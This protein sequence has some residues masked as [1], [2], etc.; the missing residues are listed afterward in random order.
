MVEWCE[1]EGEAGDG[2]AGDV[3]TCVYLCVRE[4][5]RKG[6]IGKEEEEEAEKTGRYKEREKQDREE[7]INRKREK[8]QRKTLRK[9]NKRDRRLREGERS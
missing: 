3:C 4:T 9:K 8:N 6:E 2:E 7:Q 1:D 5:E